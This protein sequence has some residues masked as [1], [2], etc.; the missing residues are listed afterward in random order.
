M[1][2]W[3]YLQQGHIPYKCF[4]MNILLVFCDLLPTY[5]LTHIPMDYIP[6]MFTPVVKPHYKVTKTSYTSYQSP[7]FI[8][9]FITCTG[10]RDYGPP[11]RG[12]Q[13]AIALGATAGTARV[14]LGCN[15]QGHCYLSRPQPYV[16]ARQEQFLREDTIVDRLL[17]E[18]LQTNTYG[19]L[20]RWQ[21]AVWYSTDVLT[22][23]FCTPQVRGLV[24]REFQGLWFQVGRRGRERR[25]GVWA[26]LNQES[27]WVS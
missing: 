24:L 17:Q 2:S 8:S 16:N 22:S 19:N 12:M 20:W 23:H 27:G 21:S 5:I 1:Q 18:K 4:E 7:N 3:K 25:D 15:V 11:G 9:S 13:W 6:N 10:A 26:G 14:K